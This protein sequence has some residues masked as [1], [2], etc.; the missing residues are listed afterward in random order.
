VFKLDNDEF[1][2]FKF[3]IFLLEKILKNSIK[4]DCLKICI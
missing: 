2:Q 4:L 3:K 1:M